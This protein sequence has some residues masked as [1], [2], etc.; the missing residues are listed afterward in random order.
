MCV[1]DGLLGRRICLRLSSVRNLGTKVNVCISDQTREWHMPRTG[2][3]GGMKGMIKAV[4]ASSQ[5]SSQ[6]A[7]PGAA[8]MVDL[9]TSNFLMRLNL[10]ASVPSMLDGHDGLCGK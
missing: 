8:L 2:G 3:C 9:Q 4:C 5:S 7:S 1:F 6:T 10:A